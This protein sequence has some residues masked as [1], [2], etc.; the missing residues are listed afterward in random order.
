MKTHPLESDD[1]R[2][3]QGAVHDDLSLYILVHLHEK[4]GI[5]ARSALLA[6][7]SHIS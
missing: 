4:I 6:G 7:N 5:T 3:L 2:M 1:I